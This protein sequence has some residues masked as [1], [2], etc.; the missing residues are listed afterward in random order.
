MCGELDGKSKI[1][2]EVTSSGSVPPEKICYIPCTKYFTIIVDDINKTQSNNSLVQIS[3]TFEQINRKKMHQNPSFL[4]IDDASLNCILEDES[5][6]VANVNTVLNNRS[7]S[8]SRTNNN[9]PYYGLTKNQIYSMLQQTRY[10]Q[11]LTKVNESKLISNLVDNVFA[12][13]PFETKSLEWGKSL[14]T[15]DK[16]KFIR[17][18][19]TPVNISKLNIKILNDLG[20]ELDLNGADWSFTIISKHQHQS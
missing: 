17:K 12:I 1:T 8:F 2:Y 11:N 13:V 5:N 18:Y 14:F 6:N 20:N 9:S 19:N 4:E 16:N 15:S 10:K 7:N 3:N